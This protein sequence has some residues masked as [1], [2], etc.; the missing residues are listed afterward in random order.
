MQGRQIVAR[1]RAAAAERGI[2]METLYAE[3][4]IS[5]SA[6]SQWNTGVTTPS[7]GS[8]NRIADYLGVT[9]GYLLSG[10]EVPVSKSGLVLPTAEKQNAPIANDE[11]ELIEI[12]Q[13]LR[14]R[15]E[16]KMLFHAGLKAK[17]DTV[18]ETAK[19]LEGLSKGES[20]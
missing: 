3:C 20:D 7:M 18:R 19:F 2:P 12:L 5:S 16:M 15:P 6:V 9:P 10:S 11:D 1:I 17:P 14:D 8:I 13:A 4:R